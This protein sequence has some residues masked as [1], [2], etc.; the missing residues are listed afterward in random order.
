MRDGEFPPHRPAAH[1][2]QCALADF[3]ARAR[4]VERGEA[5]VMAEVEH[6]VGDEEQR[7]SQKHETLLALFGPVAG[8]RA[9]FTVLLGEPLE[10]R[11]GFH[12]W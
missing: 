10:Y 8:W 7:D 1:G 6:H 11:F 12:G 9:L 2:L 5:V 3:R 4:V